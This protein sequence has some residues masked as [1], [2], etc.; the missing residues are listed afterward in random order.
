M[1]RL[2]K[3]QKFMIRLIPYIFLLIFFLVYYIFLPIYYQF[4]HLFH[5]PCFGGIIGRCYHLNDFLNYSKE[6][7]PW[8]KW[9]EGIFTDPCYCNQTSWYEI[10]FI[11]NKNQSSL[12]FTICASNAGGDGTKGLVYL[13]D[14]LIDEIFTPSSNCIKKII[15]FDTSISEHTLR[16]E[17]T[18]NGICDREWVVW[19]N[20]RLIQEL[21]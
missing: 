3:K 5:Y 19:K 16:L 17:G 1:L 10:P 8:I 4:T 11:T 21:Q 14:K 13:D 18:K 20:I 2:T 9:Q 12:E 7:R 15:S 6:C